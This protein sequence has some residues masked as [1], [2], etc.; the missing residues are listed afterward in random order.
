MDPIISLGQ[1]NT[2]AKYMILSDADNRPPMLDKDLY[3]S[4][5]SRMDQ[6]CFA[7]PVFSPGDD[8]IACLNKAMAFLTA[9]DSSRF[10]T[11]NNQLKTSSNPRNQATIQ[12]DRVTVQ[13]VQGRQGQNYSGTTYKGNATSSRGNTTSGQARVEKAMLAEAQEAGQIL[14]EE[15]LTEDLDTYDSDCDDLSSAQVVLMANI[16]NYGSDV[17]LDVPN[18]ET[19]LNDMDN[20]S[21]HALQ[22]F[23]QSPVMDFTDNEIF[24]D[25]NI[26]PYSQYLQ[27]TQQAT[28]QDTNLQ[29]QQDSMILS[30]IEQMSEQMINHVNNWEKVNKEQ[31]NESITAEL[32]RYKERTFNPTI[33]PSYS[34]PVIVDVPSELP[35]VSLVNAS[36]KK[37]KFHLT[38]FDS[39][40]KKRTT[41]SALEEE[42]F[43]INDL[44]ARLQDKHTTIS[45]LKDTIKSLENNTK[46]KN[47]HH[48][49][50]DLEPINEE[51]ENSVAKLLS[52]NEQLWNEINHVKQD[53]KAQIQ[54][55]DFL[56]TSF[57]NDLRKSK[58]KEIVENVVHIPSATTIAPGMFKLVLVPL[59][60]RLL[61][62]REVHINYLRN[63]QEQ[64]NIL[65]GI[66]EQVKAK[67]PLD[68][69][70]DLACKYTTR[71][72][73]L[74]VYVQDTCPNAITP[75]TKKVAVTPMNNVKKV[76][77]AEPLTS[78]SNIKQVESSNTSDSNT[79][80]LSSTGVK[81]TTTNIVPLKQT[82][83]HLDDI[84]KPELKVY[85]RKPKNVK[86]IGSSIKAKIVESKKADHSEP[87]QTWGSNATD[88]PSSSSLVVTAMASE[89]FSSGPGL[90]CMT[91]ATSST[92]LV[93]NPVS[94][95]PCIP[96][97]RDD[98]DLL[99]QPMFDEYFNPPPIVVSP[100]Q[101]APAPRAEVLADSPVSTSIDQD[102]PSTK[103][104]KTPTFH[105]DPLNESPNEDSTSHGSSS[106]VRQIHT[107]LEH[108]G[109]WT[110]DHPIANVIGDPSRS[111]S[112]RKQLHTDAMWC[113]FD[114]FLTSVEPKNFK[115]AMTEPSWI[116]A[117]QEEIH[118]FKRLEVKTDE[119]GRVLKNKARL[120]AQRFR[121]EKGIDFEES[122]APVARIE[123]IR[124]FVANAAHKNMII[125]QMDVKMAFLNGELKEEV[126]VS[127][128]EGFVDQDNPSHVYKLK[129]ALYGLKHAPRAWYDMLS[130]FFISQ[131]FAKGAVDA[132]LFT[133][134]VGNDI[135]L[136]KPVD[137]TLYRGM[138]GSLMYLTSSRP[139]LNYDVCL[140][141]QYQAKPTEKHL[142][143][144][145]RIF[146]YLN[147][148][149]N[150]G[151]WY[152]KDTDMS[153]TAY[154][155][156]DH[157]GC[158]DT[159]RSTSG[160]AQFL[161]DKL[162]SWSSKKQ[163]STAISS[164]EAEYIALSGCCSQILWMRSQLTDYGFKFNKIPLY[165]DNKS[166]IALCCNNTEYQL[167][168]IFTKS[169]PREKFNFLI[170][171]LI[172][173]KDI[174]C[175]SSD[176]RPPMLDRTDFDLAKRIRLSQIGITGGTVGAI[177]QGPVRARVLNDLSV[178]EKEKRTKRGGIINSWSS[179]KPSS[180]TTVADIGHIGSRM[181]RQR[182]SQDSDTSW[183]RC[184]A[185]TSSPGELVQYW[186]MT[187]LFLREQTMV[188]D[189][190]TS[191]EDP[192]YDEAR[193]SYGLKYPSEEAPDFN[194]FFKIKN[195]EHQIQEKDNVIRNL[196]VL[197]ANVNDRSCEPYNAKDVTALIEQNDCVRI[198]LEKLSQELLEYVIGTCPKSFNERDNKAPSTPVTRKNQVMFSDKPGT[199]SS[200]TLKH[201]VH[202]R[203][204][205]TNIPVLPS[206]GVNDSTEASG[207]KPRSNTKKNRILPAKKENKKEV[208]VR[209]R[210][211][212]S[213]W[214][215]VNRVD[216]SISSKRVVINSNSESVNSASHGMCVVNILNSVNA[217]PT[218]R[219]VLNKEKQI[220]KPKGKLS[221]NSLSKTQRV[222]KATGKLFADIGYQWRP[223]GK[224]LT[225]GKLDCG[226]Q[227]RPTGKKFALGEI[228]QLTKLSVKCST[229]YANQ[230]VMLWY[231]DSGC[232]K[233]MTGN[234]SKLM[235]FV[236]KFIGSVRFGNDHLGAIM[237][238]GDYVMG[239]SVISRVYYVEG[240][241]HNLFS[242]GQ[243]CDSDLEVAFRKHTC[244]VRDSKGTDI[245]KG[246]RGTNLYTISIDEMMKSSPICLLSKA[247]KSK[248][249][250]WHRRLNHLNFGMINDLARKD[251]VR[252]LPRLK[253]EKDHLCSACQLGKSKKTIGC[254]G[255]P[256][257]PQGPMNGIGSSLV[258]LNKSFVEA[259][260]AYPN[261]LYFLKPSS[262]SQFCPSITRA[263]NPQLHLG[264]PIS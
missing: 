80:V 218:V 53:L 60:P 120:V 219:I 162:V 72:Q 176:T 22:D 170:E 8:P 253:F 149:I 34:P 65:R 160:S 217:T 207:S 121:Q 12:D 112:T 168:D 195:L 68:G 9:V 136:G 163:K 202:Q 138:I 6:A 126:Y 226:S 185:N 92:G 196:K 37:L 93:L 48:E 233:H 103:S 132:T 100:V 259:P 155:D 63:T 220:W 73:V 118:E 41:P 249:W 5:K 56:I 164:T 98:W 203:V 166:A 235:N 16:S 157:A 51:L 145:K 28:V 181:S 231:L 36:L 206:T 141:A 192:I 115:Q 3:D 50:C 142:Q 31:N 49:K 167:A 158:Q 1:K 77:I 38:Q 150:M 23:K 78:S 104:P 47:V 90:Q 183:T 46:E 246:S 113:Y 43:K 14:D 15:Q 152:S 264:N 216:S 24:S 57:K 242:V 110:K 58:G 156:A 229:L 94:Q 2:L 71:I 222:W 139:D 198:E 172:C 29:A 74:L 114:A 211:N 55:K 19:Y 130:S 4:W 59:P 245:L 243:F 66:V 260:H 210:T 109:R 161:G 134:H 204:Q 178:K 10:P 240:L 197:V 70:L 107:P 194:S 241:G 177:Q 184:Y 18:S 119:S 108:I 89:Q 173:K 128:P 84:Q 97:I 20:Q 230:Q 106:N 137:A 62:N 189:R 144:V 213:V 117:I 232:S 88:I 186:I 215:K 188:P 32:E 205:L 45:K 7:V 21:V 122:F 101:E 125:Y 69:D 227:W 39:V 85:S 25:S 153:L 191:S 11:T 116:N 143:A 187:V 182:D 223:T 127:Q 151:L 193:Q 148:T 228:C 52:E 13:Q 209:L 262:C 214:T 133:R 129:K 201:K 82:I 83:S 252:G 250:L 102:A 30:V 40:V 35:K 96:P 256:N 212:K 79:P 224:K 244:F 254:P 237:G 238:Y 111:V 255:S 27:E 221:D 239:D 105:D 135:L 64:A 61:K 159:R 76:R 147:G 44:K 75:S 154:A 248:S 124:I 67:Q 91:L 199:S 234:R 236:E 146:R 54:D 99:F 175:A 251:L 225:L 190:S 247:S 257:L 42:Y 174:Q 200:N 171:K 33:E 261:V 87:N 123:A 95:Q 81:F 208:E 263:S 26:I 140:C 131:K 165:C 180:A 17:I 258:T 86:N 169:L 179:E